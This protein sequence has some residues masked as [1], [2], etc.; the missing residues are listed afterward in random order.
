[1][2]QE[3]LMKLTEA[4]VDSNAALKVA[5][6]MKKGWVEDKPTHV[7]IATAQVLSPKQKLALRAI[8]GKYLEVREPSSRTLQ[9]T[10]LVFVRPE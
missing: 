6:M 5:E 2:C 8:F 4:G 3:V 10:I 7:S 9:K 1:M